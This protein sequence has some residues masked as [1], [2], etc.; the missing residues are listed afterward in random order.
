MSTVLSKQYIVKTKFSPSFCSSRYVRFGVAQGEEAWRHSGN[1]KD[2]AET[3][4][5]FAN[6]FIL[7]LV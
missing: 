6:E 5:R 3:R 2:Q 7:F 4:K 1:M